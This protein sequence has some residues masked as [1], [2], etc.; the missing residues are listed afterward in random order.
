MIFKNFISD[1]NKFYRT[2][3]FNKLENLPTHIGIRKNLIITKEYWNLYDRYNYKA[4]IIGKRIIE[5][6]VGK[7]FDDAFSKFKKETK[8][9]LYNSYK[10]FIDWNIRI[11]NCGSSYKLYII[12]DDGNI[13]YSKYY[14]NWQNRKRSVSYKTKDYTS[15]WF[16]K[17]TNILKKDFREV[18]KY[19]PNKYGFSNYGK[20]SILYYIYDR[21]KGKYIWND[22]ILPV[23]KQIIAQ[24]EEFV[25]RTLSGKIFTFNS[26]KDPRYIRLV[27]DK[28]KPKRKSTRWSMSEQQFREILNKRKNEDKI[29]CEIKM[30]KHGFD[31]KTSFRYGQ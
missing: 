30:I 7:P 9:L 6:F 28:S 11:N 16:Y 24:P 25:E 22:T 18:Y 1:S 3:L 4:Y 2:E 19:P 21:R 27:Q 31:P 29:S 14:L 23:Y 12:D 15:D 8:G 26:G 20:N 17:N 5:H 10:D 13:Q